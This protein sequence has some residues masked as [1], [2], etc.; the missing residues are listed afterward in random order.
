MS[1]IVQ[2]LLRN[3]D[4]IKSDSDISD[5]L[6]NL[7]IVEK[8]I[9]DLYKAGMLSDADIQIIELVADGRPIKNLE[10]TIDKNRITISKVF[11]QICERIAYFIGGYFTDEGF[12]SSMKEEY[13]LSEDDIDKIRLFIKGKFK[14]QLM[15]KA[16]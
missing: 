6:T 15:R 9:S 1:W 3:R 5:N 10:G 7:N 8:K 16:Q 11:I 12:L 13:K 14:H 4:A 2:H